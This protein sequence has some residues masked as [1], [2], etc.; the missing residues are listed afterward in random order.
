VQEATSEVQLC[1]R[2]YIMYMPPVSACAIPFAHSSGIGCC[3]KSNPKRFLSVT[4]CREY[5]NERNSDVRESE[6]N[7]SSWQKHGAV[8]IIRREAGG[9]CGL[10]RL[11]IRSNLARYMVQAGESSPFGVGGRR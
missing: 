4:R 1:A 3:V 11:A 7:C 6:L 2:L 10:G 8:L 5:L 9:M